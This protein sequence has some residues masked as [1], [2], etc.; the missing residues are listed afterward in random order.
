[1]RQAPVFKRLATLAATSY[2]GIADRD[3][4]LW[5]RL[6]KLRTDSARWRLLFLGYSAG[7]EIELFEY[8]LSFNLSGPD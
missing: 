2:P 1:M 3:A 4:I 7:L 6:D 8:R 5:P